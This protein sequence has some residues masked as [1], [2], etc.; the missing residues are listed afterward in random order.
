MYDP[1]LTTN[2]RAIIAVVISS[3]RSVSYPSKNIPCFFLFARAPY[4]RM[5]TIISLVL[6]DRG[7]RF[8]SSER[9]KTEQFHAFTIIVICQRRKKTHSLRCFLP[10]FDID[11]PTPPEKVNT[12]LPP[13]LQKR[14]GGGNQDSY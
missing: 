14:G 1:L 4:F 11:F 3:T 2:P 12:F 9:R 6:D 10:V 7:R 8:C 13:T 5:I